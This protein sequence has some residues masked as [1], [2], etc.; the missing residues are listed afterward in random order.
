M[1]PP[2]RRE[3]ATKWGTRNGN[4]RKER[5]PSSDR[6]PIEPAWTVTG[7]R[8][9]Y[10]AKTPLFPTPC[11]RL[12]PKDGS[13]PAN[14]VLSFRKSFY[15][16][17]T[18]TCLGRAD[19]GKSGLR[20]R[21]ETESGCQGRDRHTRAVGGL[22]R[23]VRPTPFSRLP[24]PPAKGTGAS[25]KAARGSGQGSLLSGYTA[26]RKVSSAGAW[27]EGAASAH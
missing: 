4:P 24:R 11:W 27:P 16:P 15:L 20:S 8:R 18:K 12:S 3:C 17:R 22:L 23:G 2:E 7:T 13:V 6:A 1:S 5:E 21:E 14:C 10:E 9:R 25:A 19:V 26:R